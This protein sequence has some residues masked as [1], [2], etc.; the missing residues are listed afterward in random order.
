MNILIIRVGRA[1]DIVML[2]PAIRAVLDK[3]PEA[4]LHILTSPDGKRVLNGFDKKISR[5]VIFDRKGLKGVF[6]KR[7][8]RKQLE[9]YQYDKVFC[10][11]LNPV[12]LQLVDKENSE[13]HA[14]Q[15]TTSV[16]NYAERCLR[17]VLP[18]EDLSKRWLTLPVTNEGKRLAQQQLLEKEIR[19][20]DFVVGLHPSFSALRKFSFRNQATRSQKGWPAESFA[21]L[22]QLIDEY[23][24]SEKKRI[25]IVMDL[26]PEDRELGE[27]IVKA[28]GNKAILFIPPLNFERYKAFLQRV[29]L[30]VSP[31]TGPMHIAAA[32]GTNLVAL[33]AGH[34]P[35]DCGPYVPDDQYQVLQAEKMPQPELGLAAI[36]PEKVFEACR[37]YLP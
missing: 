23:A 31:D 37:K 6:A 21:R 13:V 26:V 18:Q 20:D 10:F 22:S 36:A 29:N 34:D 24:Q 11:E 35:R 28:S 3:W 9:E 4:S 16:T 1:G 27:T 14:I 17:V 12:F 25:F 15:T 19:D 30:L 8:V 32:V 7:E 2:T 33:F 5:L